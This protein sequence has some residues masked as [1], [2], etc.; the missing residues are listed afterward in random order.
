MREH[1]ENGSRYDSGVAAALDANQNGIVN[2][3][4]HPRTPYLNETL[5]AKHKIVCSVPAYTP[6]TQ[7]VQHRG[8]I[9]WN[10]AYKFQ[11]HGP[12]YLDPVPDPHVES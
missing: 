6:D 3:L 8:R 2:E 11:P 10:S 7:P 12:S 1:Q 9:C 5:G 4:I